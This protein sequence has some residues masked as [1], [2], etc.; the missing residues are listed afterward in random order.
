M[1][2]MLAETLTPDTVLSFHIT[3]G[4]LP[5]FLA[6]LDE[7][8]PLIKCFEGSVTL[9]S[10]GRSH[11]TVA[12]RLLYLMIAILEELEIHHTPL[13]STQWAVP[14]GQGETAYEP[15]E[16][17]YIQSHETAN[18]DQVPDLAIEIVVSNSPTKALACG[19]AL[20]IP[21]MWVFDVPRFQLAFYRLARRGKHKGRYQ[22][23]PRSQALPFLLASEVLERLDEPEQDSLEFLKNCR[24]W[25]RRV[26]V[27]RR[28]P[29]GE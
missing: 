7:R 15:D 5:Q 6:S 26:L 17:Y 2:A 13:G 9:V 11:E 22:P 23:S 8:G 16:S 28:Q 27:P 4:T 24:A 1:A 19:S 10:P 29:P 3:P 20:G 18:E 21:E 14:A 25:A 12:R